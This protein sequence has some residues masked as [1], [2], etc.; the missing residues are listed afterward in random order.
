MAL[1][2]AP[3]KAESTFGHPWWQH[4]LLGLVGGRGLV[5]LFGRCPSCPW[6]PTKCGHRRPTCSVLMLAN[7]SIELHCLRRALFARGLVKVASVFGGAA[8]RRGYSITIPGLGERGGPC[9]L[10]LWW[11]IQFGTLNHY[12]CI[13]WD[14]VMSSTVMWRDQMTGETIQCQK[15][16]V[17]SCDMDKRDQMKS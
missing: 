10:L 12:C 13:Q 14:H 15:K 2:L 3:A 7:P 4:S 1:L 16:K 11:T 6:E 5:S 17:R 9:T 8:N